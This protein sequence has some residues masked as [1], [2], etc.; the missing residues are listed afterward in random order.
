MRLRDRIRAK[1]EALLPD[2]D[3]IDET[4][5]VVKE[6]VLDVADMLDDAKEDGGI[7][8]TFDTN[9]LTGTVKINFP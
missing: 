8:L 3:E 7:V 4:V 6:F 9:L 5:A 2:A 1:I